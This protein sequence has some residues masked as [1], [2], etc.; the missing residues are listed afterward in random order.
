M[1]YPLKNSIYLAFLASALSWLTPITAVEVEKQLLELASPFVDDAVLQ[2]GMAVPVW[3]WAAPGNKITVAFAGQS[4]T[5]AADAQGKWMVKL[6][7]LTASAEER[8]MTVT[9]AKGQSITRKGLLVGEV[10]FAS[11]QSNMDW[12]AGKSRCSELASTL[13]KS[14]VDVPIR[15]YTVDSGSAL[16]PCSR[17]GS[18]EGWSRSKSAGNFSALALS[19][20]WNLHQE[21][22]VPVGIIRSSH[23]ATPSETWTAYEGFA[24]HPQLQAIAITI[25]QSNPTTVEGKAAFAKFNDDLKTWQVESEKLINL[26]GAALPRPKLPGICDDWKGASRMYNKKVAP[27]I[28]Y[29]LRGAIWCQGNT[30]PPT[31]GSSPPRWRLLSTAGEKIGDAPT[32]RSTSPRCSAMATPIPTVSVSPMFA[33]PSP[34]SSGMRKMLAWFPSM[35]SIPTRREFTT[36]TNWMPANVSPAG[37]WP[38]NTARTFLSPARSTNHRRSREARCA[39]N[40]NSAVRAVA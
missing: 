37:R 9:N 22:K 1:R 2:R 18:K 4:K 8:E 15:E 11:G 17:A 5:V 34:C 19:F 33:R 12:L 32:C 26:G 31:A 16:Y 23:G 20:A 25:R 24:E 27:L 28:P 38:T 21:L 7:P 10:W 3:G 30:T 36:P 29:A 6:E 14:K 40:S 35:I 39:F 13:A